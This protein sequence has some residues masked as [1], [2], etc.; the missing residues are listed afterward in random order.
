MIDILE[1]ATTANK[2]YMNLINYFK[3][4]NCIYTSVSGKP[5]QNEGRG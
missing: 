3:N 4:L 2:V 1:G 5:I